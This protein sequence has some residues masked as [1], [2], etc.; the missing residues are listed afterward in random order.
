MATP[1]H[2]STQSTAAPP[3]WSTNGGLQSRPFSPVE[4]AQPAETGQFATR[5]FAP[6]PSF[7]T[8]STPPPG[9]L[10]QP[11]KGIALDFSKISLFA[12]GSV[13]PP[14]SG[15]SRS[16]VQAKLTIGQPNDQYEQEADRVAAQVMSM[17]PPAAPTVQRQTLEE[18]EPTELQTKPLAETITPLVQRQAVPE[19]EEPIQAKCDTYEAE[20]PVQRLPE[21]DE[22]E[23]DV[24]AKPLAAGI[25]QREAVSED[26]D[27]E[28]AVQAKLVQRQE[29][30]EEEETAV[31]AKVLQRVELPEEEEPIQT[32]LVQRLEN[33]EEEEP[34]QAKFLQ[35]VELPEE[36]EP[37]VQRKSIATVQK[38][39]DSSGLENQLRSRKGSGSPLDEDTRSFMESRFNTDFSHVR[40][41]TDASAVQMNKDLSAQAFTHG[42]D[43]YFGAGKSPGQNE[44]TAHELTH[45]VQQ[46]GQKQ[47]QLK[48]LRYSGSNKIQPISGNHSAQPL[49]KKRIQRKSAPTSPETDPGFQSVKQR[50]NAVAN[51]QKAHPPAKT[52]ANEAQAA[53]VPPANEKASKAQDRQVQEMNQQPPGTFNTEKFKAALMEKINAATPQ[54]L[55]QADKFKS[56]DPLG[57]VKSDL[58][59]QVGNEKKQAAGPIEEKTK[60]APKTSEIADKTVTPLPP[61]MPET[62]PAD[63]GA[64]QAVPKPKDASELSMQAGSQSLDQQMAEAKVTDEQLANSNEPQFNEALGVKKEAQAHAVTAPG[65]YRQQEQAKLGQA[66]AQAQASVQAPLQGMQ[67]QKAEALS[68]VLGQQGTTKGQDEQKRSEIAGHIEGIYSQTKQKVETLLS[69][70][71]GEVNREFDQGASSAKSQFDA[72]VDQ[73]MT[74]FKDK[75]YSGIEG[76]LTWVRDLFLPLPPEVNQ[77]YQVGR[78]KYLDSMTVTIDRV[79]A[80]VVKQL[81]AAKAEIS[82][83]KQQIQKYVASLDPALQQL[84]QSAAQSIQ[85]KFD[86]LEQSIDNKQGELIDSLAQKYSDN[87]QALDA[88]IDKMKAD[89]QGWVSKAQD[90]IGGVI[91]TILE[92]KNMLMG[93]LAKAAGAVDKIIKD[94]VAFLGNLVAGIKQG[95]MG[96]VGNITTHLKKG[97]IGW[98]TG[99]LAGAGLEMPKSFDLKGIFVLV[100][101]VLGLTYQGMRDR[102]AKKVGE[103][104]VS[105]LEK[106]FDMFILLKNEGMA[107]LWKFIQDKLTNLKEMVMGGI[108]SFVIDTII[109]AGVTWVLSLLNPASAFVRACKLIVDVVMFFVE[110]GSQIAELVNAV[111]DSVNSIADGAIGVAAGLVEGALAKALPVVIGFLASLI[112]LGGISGKIQ[113]LIKKARGLVDTAVNWVL[114]KAL[115]FVKKLGGKLGLGKKV[116]ENDSK[117]DERTVEEKKSDVHKATVAAHKLIKE[118]GA[119]P[120]SI[121]AKLPSIKTNY[122]LTS[123]ELIKENETRY[124]VEAKINPEEYTPSEDLGAE[125]VNHIATNGKA[126]PC[127]QKG[128]V[129]VPVDK[130]NIYCMGRVAMYPKEELNKLQQLKQNDRKKFDAD[131]KNEERLVY[132]RDKLKHN[133]ERSQEMFETIKQIGWGDSVEVV[134]KIIS[135]LLSVGEGVTVETGNR[136]S[137]KLE[138]SDGGLKVLSTWKILPDGTKYLAT[139][140]FIPVRN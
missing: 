24:Q 116:N 63:V 58:A 81:N 28:G 89:N 82:T 39:A 138:A 41:H 106:G 84:G 100:T 68:Q 66:S 117:T 83:G 71:D 5:P 95:F 90:A 37:P 44:L 96:F 87:L 47:L 70:L 112:G 10:G 103:K 110:K 72:Y 125:I 53:V 124:H 42:S 19:E 33:P 109:S 128:S 48:G 17:A 88:D 126:I 75:R 119:T 25:L 38:T 86:Q 107:G 52:K 30:P 65:E 93:I 18:E 62:P 6:E 129:R 91:K 27:D 121:R 131:P 133:W 130:V 13:P 118:K 64:G 122:R 55:D 1:T 2:D 139:I 135:H 94:P 34:V 40:V 104:K 77:F 43:V 97:L 61:P 50:V 49:D 35:R 113:D 137:S 76:K 54:N 114:G 9:E 74:R 105:A 99:N 73:E 140:N 56:N 23:K 21:T 123:I 8:G 115:A 134:D 15:R 36:E 26:S 108:Q 22:T 11:G 59:A 67:G 78:K 57:A 80:L 46:T 102:V 31:Q 32:K 3:S 4:V 29:L 98:L 69:A 120:D 12:N 16:L 132:V 14:V 60:E 101:S 92:L 20:E 127:I 51:Q 85:G 79:A 136:Q 45:V 7:R 111:L